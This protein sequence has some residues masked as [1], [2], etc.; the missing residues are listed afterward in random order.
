LFR[1]AELFPYGNDATSALQRA[2]AKQFV[3]LF[4]LKV[5]PYYYAAVIHGA[6]NQ[7]PALIESIKT[8]IIPLFPAQGGPFI[9]GSKFGLA[10]ILLAPFVVRIYLIAKLGLLGDGIEAKLAEL[11]KWDA[12]A[13]GVLANESVK[14]TFDYQFE[15]RKAIDRVRKIR[16]ASKVSAPNATTGGA[17]PKV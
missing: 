6:A 9:I 1:E 7:G 2:R 11:G 5:N 14:K 15:A 4:L 17:S 13:R 12:W 3:E 10:E 8:F 16:E